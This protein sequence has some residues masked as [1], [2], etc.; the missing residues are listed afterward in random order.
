M[1]TCTSIDLFTCD[2][3]AALVS[4][5]PVDPELHSERTSLPPRDAVV[6][7]TIAANDQLAWHPRSAVT[8]GSAID[9]ELHSERTSLPPRDAVVHH[10][11]S[12]DD[13][14]AR[15]P[16]TAVIPFTLNPQLH[17]ERAVS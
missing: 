11:F 3:G 15:Y 14:F 1:S 9:P 4:R 16:R 8:A 5:A 10:A 17:A 13:Q 2:P 7:H 6:H 12:A